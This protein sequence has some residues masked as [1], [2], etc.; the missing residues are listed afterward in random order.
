MKLPY[1]LV[2]LLPMWD[3]IC[4]RCR[5]EVKPNSHKCPFCGEQF[6]FPLKVPPKYLQ[7]KEALERYVHE[8]IFPK[9]SA[10]QREYLAQYFTVIFQDGFE[11]GDFSAWTGTKVYSGCSLTVVTEQAH[12][13]S[14]SA[15]AV[16]TSGNIDYPACCYKTFTAQ[17]TLFARAY[18]RWASFPS[19]NNR[20]Q[21]LETYE[22][23][24]FGVINDAG[25]MKWSLWYKTGTSS[26]Y[27]KRV[28]SPTPQLN[29]WYC[30]EIK[31]VK[32]TSGEVRWYLN[33][34]EIANAT[35]INTS[36]H[37][38][39]EV[40]A[41]LTYSQSA[42]TVYLDC[43]VIADTGPIGQEGQLYEINVDAAVQ[44][45]A[46][47]VVWK[48][49]AHV[50]GTA[51]NPYQTQASF[52]RKAFYANG[53]FW[54][55]YA[56]TATGNL[57]YRTSTDGV[58]W[59]SE[60][61]IRTGDYGPH[62]SVFFDGTYVHY[63]A[64][65]YGT[66]IYYRRGVPNS[67]GSIAWSASEQTVST[68]YNKASNPHIGVDSDG[69]VWI[70]YREL[71]NSKRCPFII[72]SGNND[73]T[74]GTT[75]SGFPYQ[76]STVEKDSWAVSPIPL[77]NGKMAIVFTG[78][79][80]GSYG[81]PIHVKT[82]DGSQ[83]RSEATTVSGAYHSMFHSAV[84]EGDDVH[85]VFMRYSSG[86]PL[87]IVYAKYV[88][89]TNS[90][91]TEVTLQSGIPQKDDGTDYCAPTITRA[92][93]ELYVFWGFYP[94]FAH[95]YYRRWNGS[96]WE[97]RVDWIDETSDGFPPDH[98]WSSFYTSYNG[99][100]GTLYLT[101]SAS[102]YNIKF[103][104]LT[105]AQ[106]Y[107]V[108]VDAGVQTLSI[109]AYQTA[110]NLEEYAAVSS[111]SLHAPE[112]AFNLTE[113][114]IVKALATLG[115]ETTFNVE[116][117]AAVKTVAEV[118]VEKVA[119]ALYE[120]FLDA[121]VITQTTSSLESAFTVNPEAI[122]QVSA[123]VD[124]ETIFS[125]VKDAITQTVASPKISC[126]YPIDKDALVNP[127]ATSSLQQILDISKDA[128]VVTVSAPHIQSNLGISP[129]AAV[130]VLA[131]VSAV[132]EGEVKVTKL[133]LIIGDLAIQ[134][135]RD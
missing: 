84:A 19:S 30:L 77:T 41:G 104:F 95:I 70:G 57:V 126:I 52:Q 6:P 96:A 93:S 78:H 82:W 105:V 98:T 86:N 133:F 71:V 18:V 28:A 11:S 100:I 130:K 91:G 47:T 37:P 121:I 80:T 107:E 54:V 63:A 64:T 69:Y 72:K 10:W 15:K 90:F 115:I 85:I 12:H 45:L 123:K 79:N 17:T 73:G 109:P 51:S 48:S 34:T 39:N 32:G 122:T 65:R 94:E 4:P 40:D 128:I 38:N 119:G 125:I 75:P 87:D 92:G 21:V 118:F 5:R 89:G 16:S 8:K 66:Q 110:Y 67:D 58:S 60:N 108:Y 7:N 68:T 61:V 101:K 49:P 88:Y 29:T 20:D 24:T 55:F 134:L 13:G 83:W 81:E 62:V 22:G 25:T 9:V 124:V 26:W 131:E 76:L 111:Q 74:W 97:D 50:V 113:D 31:A 102:P 116:K 14:R 1:W 59:S 129:E 135:S 2:R 36:Q 103:A 106:T 23:A 33:G 46:S 35:G 99:Y 132:K 42:H 43:V 56:N 3:Y 127:S 112:T 117:D 114:A 120:F 27:E 53:R 44:N